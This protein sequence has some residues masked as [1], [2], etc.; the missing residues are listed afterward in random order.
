MR[1]SSETRIDVTEFV[2]KCLSLVDEVA[3]GRIGRV[4][5]TR[6]G[7][8]VVEITR[9]GQAEPSTADPWGALSDMVQLVPG[10]D[11]T[12]PLGVEWDAD[13]GILYHE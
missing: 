11:L 1:K 9:T 6:R 13:R 10:V 7:R 2:T 5:L 12:E 8:A 3:E 4:V